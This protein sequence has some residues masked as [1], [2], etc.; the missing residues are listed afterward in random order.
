[1][2]RSDLLMKLSTKNSATVKQLPVI[3]SRQTF[4]K[5]ESQVQAQRMT[6]DKH[7]KKA[8]KAQWRGN[9]LDHRFF[10]QF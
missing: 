5:L 2:V 8:M 1:M 6:L 10:I 9:I 7:R 4:R 3:I